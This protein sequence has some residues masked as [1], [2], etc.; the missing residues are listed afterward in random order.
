MAAIGWAQTAIPATMDRIPPRR[1]S[2]NPDQRRCRKAWTT[3]T[4]P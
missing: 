3:S 2:R 1:K 4:T